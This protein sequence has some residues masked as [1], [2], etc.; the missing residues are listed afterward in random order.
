[1]S[2]GRNYLAA[3]RQLAGPEP[4]F[5]DKLPF[6]FRYCG[7]IHKALPTGVRSSI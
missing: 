2:L 1:M 6:N 5:V 4:Y 3:A 7:P